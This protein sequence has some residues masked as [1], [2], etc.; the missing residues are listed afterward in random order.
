M[1]RNNRSN[2][3]GNFRRI[4]NYFLLVLFFSVVLAIQNQTAYA[5]ESGQDPDGVQ[6]S[7]WLSDV[8]GKPYFSSTSVI[9]LRPQ[10]PSAN[11]GT[12]RTTTMHA[13][14]SFEF[15]RVTAGSYF[16]GVS[17]SSANSA[18][19]P[20]HV[21]K[22]DIRNIEIA[23]TRVL[24]V[25]GRIEMNGPGPL[26]NL[27]F[28]L[29]PTADNPNAVRASVPASPVSGTFESSV[30]FLN[31]RPGPDGSFLAPIP[32][33]KWYLRLT[34]EL[35]SGYAIRKLTY[36]GT[37]VEP[38]SVISVGF[39]DKSEIVVSL[40]STE[41]KT[42][43]VRGRI[44]GL[45]ADAI[46]R[47]R[48]S[49]SV[50][51]GDRSSQSIPPRS[52]RPLPD[53]TFAIAQV[54][55]GIYSVLVG[56]SSALQLAIAKLTVEHSDVSDFEIK[57]DWHEIR[58]HISVEGPS[59]VPSSFSILFQNNRQPGQLSASNIATPSAQI[60]PS[61][62]GSFI[63]L[64]PEGSRTL[65]AA[66]SLPAGFTYKSVFY[67]RIDILNNPFFISMTDTGE[68]RIILSFTPKDSK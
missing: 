29:I 54:L 68:L 15:L 55:P 61:T 51:G 14:G 59:A 1:N 65:S 45:S 44:T 12:P 17:G 57:S 28:Q 48:V 42:Y 8:E 18:A 64:L 63:L 22:S 41:T 60:R 52:V 34:S 19:V 24:Q 62:D 31:A 21:Q 56:G 26:P 66:G 32:E 67:G 37:D 6:V 40:D 38:G 27:Q 58:G 20:V 30:P 4:D 13:D 9:Y 36:G 3:S 50:R 23:V 16:L 46:A 11:N 2:G 47:E 10:Q 39:T 35:P 25:S 33:G 49:I 7:G 43:L 53:G 5:T